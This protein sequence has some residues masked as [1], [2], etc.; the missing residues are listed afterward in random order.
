MKKVF[1]L[2]PVINKKNGQINF[3][4]PKRKVSERLVKEIFNNKRLRVL[5]EGFEE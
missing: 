4:L 3:S 5:L 1:V 2:K